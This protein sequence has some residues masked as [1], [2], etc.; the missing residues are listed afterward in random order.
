MP[1]TWGLLDSLP[2]IDDVRG[3]RLRTIEGLPPLLI[4]PPDACRFAAAVQLRS[5]RLPS[6][7]AGADA[8][9]PPK[10]HLARCWG[11]E[12]RRLASL[13]ATTG[14]STGPRPHDAANL[15]E[16]DDLKVHF[17][18]RAG[19]LQADGRNRSRRSTG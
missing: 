8:V 15:V 2:R 11:T 17:P 10:R 4:R 9:A 14:S 18:I 12:P 1:Y 7:R 5:R 13:T 6:R 3:S 19:H 16:V